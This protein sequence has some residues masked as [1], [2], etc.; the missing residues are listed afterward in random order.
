MAEVFAKE[1]QLNKV[2]FVPAGQPYHKPLDTRITTDDRLAMV[3]LAIEGNPLF[4]WSD[5]DILRPGNTYTIDT[6]V[7]F[8]QQVGEQGELWWLMGSDSLLHL[9]S[10][11]EFTKIFHVANLAVAVREGFEWAKLD[12]VVQ[13]LGQ[14]A[15]QAYRLGKTVNHG[16]MCFLSMPLYNIASSQ[17]RQ[18]I[19]S[20]SDVSQWIS[21]SVEQYIK[22]HKLYL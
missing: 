10:W 17:I 3:K 5:C 4:D 15:L 21:P 13:E 9:H 6:L 7:R 22:Q 20:S 11:H 8:K 2:Y 18:A 16:K 12:P 14:E 1:L 19:S